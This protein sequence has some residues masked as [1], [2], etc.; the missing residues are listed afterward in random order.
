M[1]I[2]VHTQA[3]ARPP[4]PSFPPFPEPYSLMGNWRLRTYLI[5]ARSLRRAQ[6]CCAIRSRIGAVVVEESAI[7]FQEHQ[8]SI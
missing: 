8:H 1:E 2:Q 7:E 5:P 6:Q 4:L 3:C